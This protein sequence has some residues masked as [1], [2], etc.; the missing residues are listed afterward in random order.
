MV[1]V[2]ARAPLF[3]LFNRRMSYGPVPV[4]VLGFFDSGVAWTRGDRP[5]FAGGTRS[6]VS[7]A[8]V[9]ARVNALGFVILEFNAARPL[10]RP[11]RG[12]LY[13]FNLRPGF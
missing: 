11:G 2:E 1:N 4:E 5:E 13:V 12:W 10:D 3:G 9:G 6:W 8:G 7:S